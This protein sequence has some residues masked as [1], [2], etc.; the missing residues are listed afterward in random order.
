[1]HNS[2]EIGLI[3]IDLLANG[4]R[5]PNLALMKISSYCKTKAHVQ[6]LFKNTQLEN[7]DR[8]DCVI[9]SKVFTF[10]KNP[11]EINNLIELSGKT[12]KELN[13]CIVDLINSLECGH[14]NNR[15]AIGGTG[16]FS[17]GGRDLHETIEHIFPDYD[18]YNEYVEYMID[19]GR[20]KVYFNDYLNYSIGFTTRGCFRKCDFCV[21]K[22]YDRCSFHAHVSE[23]VDLNRPG[24]YL[25]DDNVFACKDWKLVFEELKQ[26]GKPFQ[27]RQGLDIRLLTE[28]KAKILSKAKYTGDVIFA[29]D[30]VDDFKLMSKKLKLWRKYSNKP[31]KLYILC[32]FDSWEYTPLN[33]PT[34]DDS[35]P[36][37]MKIYNADTQDER[38]LI[39]IEGVFYRISLLMKFGCLP[40]VMRFEMYKQ[41]KYRGVYVQL[42]RWCNQPQFYKKM[43]FREFCEAN[44]AYAKSDKLCAPMRCLKLLEKDSPRISKKYL[45]MKY[46]NLHKS[47]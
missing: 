28:K 31:T 27:F 11:P 29:F 3:D 34:V 15:I 43:S 39:D 1:M 9:I 36:H 44:Q 7:L 42:A 5:H 19:N 17:D 18:L 20:S 25:W 40:Y 21:N 8:F 37:I 35:K 13:L 41:S 32:A 30:H 46:S 2:L 45:D 38:D 22:K 26:T 23:F 47:K 4:T 24:I 16:F 10:S 12:L 6:L 14:S 33:H